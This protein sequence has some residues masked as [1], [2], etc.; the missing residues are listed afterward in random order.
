MAKPYFY[1]TNFHVLNHPDVNTTFEV[2]LK[3]T[4]EEFLAWVEKTRE[5]ILQS[6]DLYDCPL[7][8]GLC[9]DEIVKQFR[10]LVDRKEMNASRE[11]ILSSGRSKNDPS[12]HK[13]AKRAFETVDLEDPTGQTMVVQ[14]IQRDGTAIDQFFPTMMKTRINYGNSDKGYSVYD[15]FADKTKFKKL[16]TISRKCLKRDSFYYFSQT[17]PVEPGL[18]VLQWLKKYR[19]LGMDSSRGLWIDGKKDK[20]AGKNSGYSQVDTDKQYWMTRTQLEAAI[21][22]GSV[23]R[24]MTTNLKMP[25]SDDYRYY[26]RMY[27]YGKKLFPHAFKAFR[28]GDIQIAV[29][30]PPMTAKYL[31]Q[32][33][34]K[35]IEGQ[36]VITV[37]DPSSGWGGRILG[38]MAYSRDGVTLHYVGN[39]P[40]TD[41]FVPE[42]DKTRYQ[43]V[44]EFFNEKFH[45]SSLW[46]NPNT[47]EIFQ[48]GSET[49]GDNPDFQKYRG[50][51]DFVFTSPPYFAKEAY[52]EDPTQSYKAYSTYD[53]WRDQFLRPTLTTAVEYLKEDRYLAWNIA[54]VQFAGKWLPLEQDSIDILKSLG[55]V[56]IQ[57]HK[58]ALMNMPGQ[59]RIGE[60]GKPTSGSFARIKRH[61]ETKTEWIKTEPLIVAYKPRK[62][63]K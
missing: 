19:D 63:S 35:H 23:T 56:N 27:A 49:I 53:V 30:F 17:V 18:D 60:D 62:T 45:G 1:E 39:D 33:Y 46:G 16:V 8:S 61:D 34:T 36:D 7:K 28:I 24:Q 40:N 52:S 6:W 14:N 26:V 10:E 48:Q 58:M 57:R 4:E 13:I 21:A 2:L 11:E 43:I 42:V 29:N 25:L 41:N 54:D 37:Y 5:V 44:A 15:L 55:M 3:M 59:N 38:A 32:K 47:F 31:Y 12:R 50:K 22:E 9:E 51:L 20:T